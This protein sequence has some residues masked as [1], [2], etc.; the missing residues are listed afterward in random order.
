[1]AGKIIADTIETGAGADI[2][3]SY[4]VEGSAKAWASWNG[5][6]TLAVNDSLNLSSI[7]DLGTGNYQLNFSSS[8][9][10]DDYAY[11]FTGNGRAE[12][13]RFLHSAM[14]YTVATGSLQMYWSGNLNG[15]SWGVAYCDTNASLAVIHGDLA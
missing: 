8:L 7:S 11:N 5:A 10:N 12:S 13:S 3:T 4:V 1:M 14:D 15:V 2:S 6:G 9:N